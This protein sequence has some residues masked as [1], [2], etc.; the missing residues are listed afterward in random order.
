MNK[1][2]TSAIILNVEKIALPNKFRGEL[3]DNFTKIDS[4]DFLGSEFSDTHE[5]YVSPKKLPMSVG[6]Y[7]FLLDQNDEYYGF[8]NGLDEIGNRLDLIKYSYGQ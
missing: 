4:Y 2:E 8:T 3:N 7:K 5:M 1:Q 6:F